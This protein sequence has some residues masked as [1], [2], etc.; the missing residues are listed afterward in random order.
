MN[1]RAPAIRDV[2]AQVSGDLISRMRKIPHV[3]V[4]RRTVHDGIHARIRAGLTVDVGPLRA[5]CKQAIGIGEYQWLAGLE[6]DDAVH[7][8]AS[9]DAVHNAIHVLTQR[10]SPA[11]R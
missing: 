1:A 9:D 10:S 8:P 2:A 6:R 3:E 7:L 4:I 11:Y 5:A